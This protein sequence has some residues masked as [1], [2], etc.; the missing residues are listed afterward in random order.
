[1]FQTETKTDQLIEE[2]H[3][4]G[5][6][7]KDKDFACRIAKSQNDA[8]YIG[9]GENPPVFLEDGEE[10]KLIEKSVRE[11]KIAM[12]L[13]GFYALECGLGALCTRNGEKPTDWLQRIVSG[14]LDVQD[15]SLLNHFANAT[16][17]AC[18]PFRGL[19]RINRPVF[20]VFSL[21]PQEE[22]A[23]DFV[24]IQTAAG[25]LLVSLDATSAESAEDQMISVKNLIQDETYALE[26]AMFLAASYYTGQNQET[27]PFISREEEQATVS[28]SAREEK[29]AMNLAGF[30][31]LESGVD[32]L[33]H[34][35]NTRP[36]EILRCITGGTILPSD[37]QLLCRFANATWKAGQPFRGLDR[38]TREVFT[39]FDF[40][41]EED[42]N[43]DWAQIT[44]AAAIVLGELG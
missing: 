19:D 10:T 15:V 39:L 34:I 36:S 21:L 5:A 9:M 16:W 8:Y 2:Q 28:K 44:G 42:K 25:K 32:Y 40:L 14:E 20:T 27:P 4:L 13:A 24:Q 37:R 6:L 30:Y 23:K 33:A 26:M 38:I 1:M 11:E 12:N 17:K 18:Q 3:L 35:Q 22:V 41:S 43:K 29:I 7:L 31:A